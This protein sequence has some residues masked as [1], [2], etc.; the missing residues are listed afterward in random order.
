MGVGPAK[1]FAQSLRKERSQSRK[2][3]AQNKSTKGYGEACF[4]CP[5]SAQVYYS[6]QPVVGISESQFMN[7]DGGI[8]LALE[9]GGDKLVVAVGVAILGVGGI[10]VQKAM[11]G[12]FP[13]GKADTSL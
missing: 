9:E 11:S 1:A 8:Y 3:S 5:V 2:F 4:F 13:A 10:E 12:G 7:E 6:H